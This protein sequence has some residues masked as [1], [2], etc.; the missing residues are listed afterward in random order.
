MTGIT[1]GWYIFLS[2]ILTLIISVGVEYI[3]LPVAIVG[4]I[5]SLGLLLWWLSGFFVSY[6]KIMG[7]PDP[8]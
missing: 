3:G 6:D 1:F 4:G 2:I 7:C 8:R 5:G